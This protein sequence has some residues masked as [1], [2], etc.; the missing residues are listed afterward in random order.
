MTKRNRH[1]RDDK[2]SE[3]REER[4]GNS[5]KTYSAYSFRTDVL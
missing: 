1:S 5:R 3:E 2:K 4:K